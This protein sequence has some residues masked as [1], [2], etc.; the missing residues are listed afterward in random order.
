MNICLFFSFI[1]HI[2]PTKIFISSH[3]TKTGN[4]VYCWNIPLN[5]FPHTYHAA[6]LILT[7]KNEN[8]EERLHFCQ[9]DTS[10][11]LENSVSGSLTTADFFSVLFFGHN[12]QRCRRRCLSLLPRKSSL[13]FQ[14]S[15]T[16]MLTAC[17]LFIC[18]FVFISRCS[19][20]VWLM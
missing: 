6:L 13:C 8:K 14:Q 20:N 15:P 18:F 3:I 9:Q 19:G 17:I 16:D 12:S 2:F 5:V 11:D 1:K 4:D 7:E 10:A